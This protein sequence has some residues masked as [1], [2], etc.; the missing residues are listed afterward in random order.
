MVYRVE[1]TKTAE[2]DLEELYLWVAERAPTQGPAWLNGLEARIR[3]LE[4]HPRR[5]RIARDNPDAQH[6]VRVLNYGRRPHV[7]RVFFT[8]D[9]EPKVVR[10][11]HIRRGLRRSPESGDL[12]GK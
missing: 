5:C 10:V 8:I 1:L 6:P 4:E 12:R 2:T 3:S 7:F 11:L 9:Q